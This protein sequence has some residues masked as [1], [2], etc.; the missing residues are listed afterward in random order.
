M[1]EVDDEAKEIVL[2]TVDCAINPMAMGSGTNLKML[3]Y[4]ASGVPV[5]STPHGARG[6]SVVDGGHLQL[7]D[8]SHFAQ[9]L[10]RLQGE[11]GTDAWAQ[12][13][14]AARLLVQERYGWSVIARTFLSRIHEG[15]GRGRETS[16]QA[17]GQ[18]ALR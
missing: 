13:I 7:S 14:A 2:S 1:G 8:M 11:V 10:A 5:I 9:A 4:F 3:D 16:D 15:G 12:R 18:R 6:L 17:I